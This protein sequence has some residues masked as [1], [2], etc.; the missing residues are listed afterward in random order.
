MAQQP[1]HGLFRERVRSIYLDGFKW[2]RDG[3]KGTPGIF[4]PRTTDIHS[5]KDLLIT[6]SHKEKKRRATQWCRAYYFAAQ[7]PEHHVSLL[8]RAVGSLLHCNFERD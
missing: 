6:F 3:R 2:R 4:L 8:D 5:D 7:D 1:S